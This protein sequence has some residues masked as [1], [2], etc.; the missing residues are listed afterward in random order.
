MKFIRRDAL[1]IIV[2]AL[3]V[4]C[5]AACRMIAKYDMVTGV[6]NV[7][8][9]IMR[10]GIYAG[11]IIAW[12]ISVKRRILHGAARRYLMATALLMLFWLSV[13]TC[14]Y[15][16]LEGMVTAMRM[17]WYGY[18]IPML[19]IPLMLIFMAECLGERED[20]EVP[21]RSR[22][23]YIPA[24]FLILC[25][26]TND[27][28]QMVFSFPDALMD[29][30]GPY[31]HEVLYSVTFGWMAAEMLI[32]FVLL[33]RHSH[34]PGKHK[35]LWAPLIPVMTGL[36]YAVG[37]LMYLKPLY[38]IASDMTVVLTLVVIAT[39][40][41]CIRSGLIPSNSRYDE[42]FQASTIGAQITD[43]DYNVVYRSDTADD[44]DEKL[45]R[46]TENGPVDLGSRRL[47]GAVIN[48]GHVLWS[49]DVSKIKKLL[50]DLE[51][52]GERLAKNNELLK[53]EVDLKE[54]RAQADEQMRLYDKI[55]QEVAP[56]LHLLETMLSEA[57]E[58]SADDAD[59]EKLAHICVI[60]SYIK[61]R[62]N[63]VLLGEE[64]SYLPAQEL[65]YC[66]RESVEN[67]RLCGA[68]VSLVCRCE[69]IVAKNSALDGY[70]LFE[71]ILESALTS[72]SALLVNVYVQN[73]SVRMNMSLSC[74][75]ESVMERC[76]ALEVQGV[77]VSAEVQD[78][79]IHVSFEVREGRRK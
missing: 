12:G 21:G 70:E 16:F 43:N 37:Y 38:I 69:G 77:D 5:A 64:T 7:F 54:K 66:M 53:A 61:R 18:Y 15:L 23:L 78:G 58:S 10:T 62:G 22:L 8:F 50:S 41:A 60:S 28:H 36:M 55:A 34:V 72:L 11:I 65:E 56:Q 71:T 73:G 67:I 49:D 48:G 3:L 40:E 57:D 68:A 47:S 33:F 35:R 52:T 44:F 1:S 42:L 26:L 17:C 4:I 46:R 31:S 74:S 79:D 63:L 6:F 2:V 30:D 45:M 14:K 27:M 51:T 39:C 13:R 59:K 76:R 75:H 19:L 25:V 32:F 24:V 29:A 20:F 9:S